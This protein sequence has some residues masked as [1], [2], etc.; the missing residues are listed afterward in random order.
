ML[1]VER[2]RR[3]ASERKAHG[4][5]GF[6]LSVDQ[7]LALIARGDAREAQGQE[8]KPTPPVNDLIQAFFRQ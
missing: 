8:D 6:I 3:I 1:D 7:V 2:I 4:Q 5:V